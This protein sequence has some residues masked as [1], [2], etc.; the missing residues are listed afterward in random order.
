MVVDGVGCEPVP[1]VSGGVSADEAPGEEGSVGDY[2]FL[3]IFDIRDLNVA[4]ALRSRFAT[5]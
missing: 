1:G 2:C 5:I 3:K 4:P